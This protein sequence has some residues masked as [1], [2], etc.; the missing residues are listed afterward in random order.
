MAGIEATTA[1]MPTGPLLKANGVSPGAS[2]GM[3][4]GLLLVLRF[5][6]FFLLSV[7]AATAVDVVGANVTADASLVVATTAL[8]EMKGLLAEK[9]DGR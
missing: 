5:F 8:P 4:F 2:S 9:T 6:S 3:G 1:G 7:V